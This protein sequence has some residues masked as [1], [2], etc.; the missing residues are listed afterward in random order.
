MNYGSFEKLI[1]WQEANK[2]TLFTYKITKYFPVDEKYGLISQMRRCSSSVMANIAE[3][4]ERIKRNDRFHFFV[5]AKSSLVE[6]HCHSVLSLQLNYLTD[7]QHKKM[8]ELI[9]KTGYLLKKF[10]LSQKNKTF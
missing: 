8:L 7:Q 5:M 3:G 9:N 6:L 2:L 4:N 10:M 1:V